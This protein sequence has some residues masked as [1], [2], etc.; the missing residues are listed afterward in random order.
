MF[1]KGREKMRMH[2]EGT[3][4][5]SW[6]IGDEEEARQPEKVKSKVKSKVKKSWTWKAMVMVAIPLLSGLVTLDA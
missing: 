2:C 3:E 4:H 5:R 6:P 1:I